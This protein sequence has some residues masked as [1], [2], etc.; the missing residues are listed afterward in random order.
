MYCANGADDGRRGAVKDL[1]DSS[2]GAAITTEAHNVYHYLV[3]MH[4]CAQG[5]RGN[6][7][8]PGDARQ[9]ARGN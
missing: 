8:I 4:G 3:A 6:K 9:L 2:F 7:D 5:V 1:H